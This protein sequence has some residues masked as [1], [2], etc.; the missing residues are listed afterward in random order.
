MSA[1]SDEEQDG[2]PDFA[3]EEY[4]QESAAQAHVLKA[5]LAIVDR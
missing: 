4:D 2:G 3:F 1:R 5:Q